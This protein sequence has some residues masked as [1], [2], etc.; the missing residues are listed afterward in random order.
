MS[1]RIKLGMMS[2]SNSPC[3]SFRRSYGIVGSTGSLLQDKG[4]DRI[5]DQRSKRLSRT[6]TRHTDRPVFGVGGRE[7]AV[8]L[9]FHLSEQI[10]DITVLLTKGLYW[11]VQMLS[12]E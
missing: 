8:D 11:V 2:S 6:W 5:D 1:I 9:I 10:L 4:L 7:D 3:F 12:G